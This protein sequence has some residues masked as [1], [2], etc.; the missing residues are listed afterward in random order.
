MTTLGGRILPGVEA[1]A[2]PTAGSPTL[3][4]LVP[5]YNEVESLVRLHAE[6]AEV[7]DAEGLAW[8][9]VFVDDG[10]RD[11]SVELLEGLALADPRVRLVEFQANRGQTAAL[12]A[13]LAY[14][15]GDVIVPMDADL[16]NDP[17]DIPRLLAKLDEGYD[18]V[19]G[20]RHD[21]QDRG[22][23]RRLP[24]FVA[25]RLISRVTG[26]RLH[27]YGCSLKAYRRSVVEHIH[28][29]GEMHRFVPIY[30]KDAG[31]RVAELP[32]NHRPR[33][34]GRSKYGLTRTPKVIIDLI[35][36]QVLSRYGTKPGYVF[37][38][39][40]FVSFL[41]SLL[42]AAGAIYFKFFGDKT[43]SSTPLP[44]A[45]L[46]LF[47]VGVQMVLMGVL[48][49]LVVR[50]YHDDSRHQPT[51]IVRRV[52]GAGLPDRDPSP[53]ELVAAPPAALAPGVA[54]PPGR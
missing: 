54:G 18:V 12:A 4:V 26:V 11:G 10:S 28:L 49:E 6:L 3:S 35:T 43:F 30:A 36:L 17:H 31:A 22:L 45:S 41:L 9:V 53:P 7:L 20:W 38:G 8:E 2:P 14:A 21:R 19:S 42:A 50:V 23:T 34:F 46:T 16:Q 48:A 5:V 15:R 1:L 47:S 29:M 33:E 52:L 40:G 25:N 51:Y 13:G 44:L 32:V 27:D 24:S 39:L 37:G